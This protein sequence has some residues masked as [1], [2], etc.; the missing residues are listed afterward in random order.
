MPPK[1]AWAVVAHG[2][3]DAVECRALGVRYGDL[4]AVRD[5]S[6][7]VAP[8]EVL[9]I[10][11]PNG[12]GKT[13]TVETLE[14]YRTAS[15]GSVRVLG[16]DPHSDHRSLVGRIGVML[17]NGGIYPTMT[18]RQAVSLFARYYENTEDPAA[19]IGML[20]LERVGR[21]PWRRLSGGEQQR[22]SL[23]LAL[24]GRPD[25]AFLDEPTAGVDPEG[26]IVIR[27]VVSDLRERGAAVLLTT[28]EL[29]EAERIADRIV[30]MSRGSAIA[31]GTLSEL[32]ADAGSPAIAFDAPAGI[33]R[34][35]LAA[36]LGLPAGSVTEVKPG[37]YTV[38]AQGTPARVASLT[39]WLASHDVTVSNLRTGAAG[40][41]DIYLSLVADERESGERVER[42]Q[43]GE[44]AE[45]IG[46][47]D[48]IDR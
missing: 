44:R 26:R 13:S 21:T 25:V 36:A 11:G 24:V 18:P 32:A 39:A 35:A 48:P 23:A 8:G 30:I 46:R 4:V 22:L 2:T 37:A 1:V 27:R 43:S 29:A 5:L 38:D 7:S 17:Q 40:L 15:S 41:E 6:F 28:H 33:D 20:G 9:A 16:L 47:I 10:L 19:L 3:H 31:S 12:A 45:R 42:E 34:P 14:G